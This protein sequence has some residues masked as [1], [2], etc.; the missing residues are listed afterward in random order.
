ME[1]ICIF[2]LIYFQICLLLGSFVS[3]QAT[4]FFW[5]NTEENLCCLHYD[6]YDICVAGGGYTGFNHI[7]V[8]RIKKYIH[9]TLM[10]NQKPEIQA[11]LHQLLVLLSRHSLN[12]PYRKNHAEVVNKLLPVDPVA[13][14]SSPVVVKP[15]TAEE[16]KDAIRRILAAK[17]LSRLFEK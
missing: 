17:G 15:L 11:M 3:L 9:E 5:N 16:Q 6:S 8:P 14:Q 7:D 4:L 10:P 2:L 1:F 12:V 13:K